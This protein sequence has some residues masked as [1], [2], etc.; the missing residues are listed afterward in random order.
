MTTNSV[1]KNSFIE[2]PYIE[3]IYPE[4]LFPTS[5][6]KFATLYL[7]IDDIPPTQ[8]PQTILFSIDIS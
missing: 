6:Q 4:N 3:T 1:I 7:E 5:E 2:I 8:E